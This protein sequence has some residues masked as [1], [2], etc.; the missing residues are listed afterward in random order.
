MYLEAGPIN[1]RKKLQKTYLFI[2]IDIYHN[3]LINKKLNLLIFESCNEPTKK[4]DT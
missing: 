4:N 1:L 3:I 2:H